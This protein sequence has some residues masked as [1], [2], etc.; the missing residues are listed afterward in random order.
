MTWVHLFKYPYSPFFIKFTKEMGEG[1]VY[2]NIGNQEKLACPSR[3]FS[4][5]NFMRPD[6][7]KQ[8]LQKQRNQKIS[9]GN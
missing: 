2:N 3:G 1:N 7:G 4:V 5:R 8:R 6:W 9:L